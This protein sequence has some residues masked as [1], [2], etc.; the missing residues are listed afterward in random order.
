[1]ETTKLK[2]KIGDHEFEADGPTE[3]V[4]A[5]LAAFQALVSL[6]GNVKAAA[7]PTDNGSARA[8][9]DKTELMLDRIMK[10]DG[11]IVSLTARTGTLDTEILLILLGQKNLRNNESVT[12]SEVLDGLKRTGHAINRVDYRLDKMSEGADASVITIGSG[13]ARRYRLT[14]SGFAKAQEVAM[15]LGER[16]A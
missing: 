15:E 5:Q 7:T 9:G 1:M 13:R 6:A 12:G 2:M 10:V 3:I 16:I 4:Q 11:R 14:N 8:R